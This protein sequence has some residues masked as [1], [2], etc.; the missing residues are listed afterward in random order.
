[1][2]WITIKSDLLTFAQNHDQINSFGTGYPEKFGTDTC[3][4]FN[5][6]SSDRL[7]YPLMFADCEGAS[8]QSTK[9]VLTVGVYLMDRVENVRQIGDVVSGVVGLRN[10]QDE[11]LSDMLQV[12]QDV[13]AYFTNDPNLDYTLQSVT[14]LSRF[15]EAFDD[16]LCGWKATLN[17]DV[18]FSMNV[19]AIPD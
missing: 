1:M 4:N 3:I 12:A 5:A 6:P 16:N 14:N 9:L 19:C 15:Y 11:V 7:I 2:S 13:I 10:N 8:T 17:F 18:P